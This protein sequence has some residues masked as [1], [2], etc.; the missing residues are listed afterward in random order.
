MMRDFF[1]APLWS[2]FN[3]NFYRRILARSAAWGFLYLAYLSF[4][5]SVSMVFLVRL[6]FLPPAH[7][8]VGWLAGSLPKMVLTRQGIQMDLNEPALLSHPQWGPVLYLDPAKDFPD[9]SDLE[10]A[11][12]VLT[13]TKVAYRDPVGG[14]YRIQDLVQ[15]RT[16]ARAQDLVVTGDWIREI[17]RRVVPWLTPISLAAF[18]VATYLWKLNAA[19]AYSLVGLIFNLFRKERLPYRSLLN[20]SFCVL[21]P[22]A[23]LQTLAWH[24][25]A[26]PIP[27]NLLMGL[28]VTSIYLALA[29]LAT[30]PRPSSDT[31][32]PP[33]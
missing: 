20:V 19:F 16:S 21:T 12:L 23:L 14:D 27:V 13:R 18:F 11:V 4:L 5:L 3:L 1:L 28:L 24:F 30:Q 22:A 25:P 31:I 17:W 29:V 8:F 6:Q 10:K 15:K 33:A 32:T 2:F 7:E 9:S 26:W